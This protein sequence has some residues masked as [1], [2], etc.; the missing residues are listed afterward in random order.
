M[1]DGG[2]C[3]IIWH[4]LFPCNKRKLAIDFLHSPDYM[5]IIGVISLT[6]GKMV[7]IPARATER[8]KN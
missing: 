8:T 3:N 1:K 2:E 6:T 7:S 5:F 4:F